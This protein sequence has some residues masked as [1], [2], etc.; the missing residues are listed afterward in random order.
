MS[1]EEGI[2]LKSSSNNGGGK[3]VM[4]GRIR[5]NGVKIKKGD[6]NKGGDQIDG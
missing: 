1:S 4:V 6:S 2:Q 3:R 5:G